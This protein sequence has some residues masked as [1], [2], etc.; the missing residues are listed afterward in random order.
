MQAI[1]KGTALSSLYRTIHVAAH[2]LTQKPVRYNG[3]YT[4]G[5]TDEALHKHT[6]DVLRCC[7]LCCRCLCEQVHAICLRV[8][9]VLR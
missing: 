2:S 9:T 8:S 4:D 5:G 3:A 6:V 1:H 7:R